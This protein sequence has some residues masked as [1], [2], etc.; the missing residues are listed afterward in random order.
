MFTNWSYFVQ[1]GNVLQVVPQPAIAPP[2]VV[3]IPIAA[4]I[5]IPILLAH[6]SVPGV[7][8]DPAAI[9]GIKNT[10]SQIVQYVNE[11]N[12]FSAAL[13]ERRILKERK[14]AKKHADREERRKA[15]IASKALEVNK[16]RYL[17]FFL[18]MCVNWN[19]WI[20]PCLH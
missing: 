11:S 10:R 12:L 7:V 2:V 5:P 9:E 13:A 3:G 16:V 14:K 1:V 4:G 8:T 17:R 20:N 6:P 15:R 18:A 19:E